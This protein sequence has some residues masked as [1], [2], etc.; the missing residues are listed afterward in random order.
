MLGDHPNRPLPY[1]WRV[2]ASSCHDPIL[3]KNG[4]SGNPGAVHFLTRG[5]EL[6]ERTIKVTSLVDKVIEGLRRAGLEIKG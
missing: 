6:M 5:R 3:S 1:L 4:V 2:S